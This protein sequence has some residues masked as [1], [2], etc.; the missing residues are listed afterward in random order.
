MSRCVPGGEASAKHELSQCFE[1]FLVA[2]LAYFDLPR[3]GRWSPDPVCCLPLRVSHLPGL[4]F[5][6][7][8]ATVS[9][10]ARHAF[11]CCQ[12][13]QQELELQ[14]S[15]H[16]RHVQRALGAMQRMVQDLKVLGLAAG[17]AHRLDQYLRWLHT[18]AH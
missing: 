6:H 2:L 3:S 13:E 14:L 12:R 10:R 1:A 18:H 7:T 11:I 9:R 16:R 5:I 17:E 15:E 4:S 8:T